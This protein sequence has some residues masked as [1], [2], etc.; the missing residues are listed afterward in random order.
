MLKPAERRRACTLCGHQEPRPDVPT[1]GGWVVH[2]A[3]ADRYP[4]VVHPC[5][6]RGPQEPRVDVSR[7]PAHGLGFALPWACVLWLVLAV[8]VLAVIS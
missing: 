1:M 8:I 7:G 6:A 3:C 4:M 5:H 2:E